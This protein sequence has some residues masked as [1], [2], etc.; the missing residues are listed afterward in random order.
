MKLFDYRNPIRIRHIELRGKRTEVMNHKRQIVT[1]SRLM[2]IVWL[3]A[4]VVAVGCAHSPGVGGGAGAAGAGRNP[5]AP[6]AAGGGGEAAGA[7][8]DD[9]R[10]PLHQ[11]HV[12]LPP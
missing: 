2:A 9:P 1:S 7:D 3:F 11:K 8:E 4:V 12:A 6:Q 10:Q 5:P